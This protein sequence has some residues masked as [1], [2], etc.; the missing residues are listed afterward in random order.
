M[1]AAMTG[2]YS[3]ELRDCTL[4]CSSTS[5]C[6]DGQVC[7]GDHFCAAPAIAG[8]CSSLP[9][10]A[11]SNNRDA[12]VGA[13]TM[14]ARPDAAPD[15]PTHVA[16]TINIEGQGR[17]NV[18]GIGTCDKSAPQ[19][20]SCILVV[21]ANM[22]VTAEAEPYSGQRFEKWTTVICAAMQ[23]STCTFTPTMTT[24]VGVKFRKDD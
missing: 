24:P 18:Q 10:G 12:G 8:S 1:L 9:D 16:L 23:S 13:A 15:A 3:P 2:C 17:L 22:P 19:N 4:T 20:G 5:D 14:D 7:G 11:G 21:P 6:A